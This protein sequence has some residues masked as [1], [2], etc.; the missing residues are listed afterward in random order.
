MGTTEEVWQ[1]FREAAKRTGMTDALRKAM[2]RL[3]VLLSM[4]PETFEAYCATRM[5]EV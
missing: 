5:H 2:E 1:E 4:K 3:P